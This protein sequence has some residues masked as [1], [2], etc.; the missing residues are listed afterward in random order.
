VAKGWKNSLLLY[1]GK[2]GPAEGKICGG[3][4]VLIATEDISI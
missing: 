2:E 3:V 4:Y 1:F